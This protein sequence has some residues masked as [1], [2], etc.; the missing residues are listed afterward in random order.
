LKLEPHVPHDVFKF[1]QFLELK[2]KRKKGL[3]EDGKN[4]T[5]TI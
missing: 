2:K 5:K 4:A 1:M 3:N